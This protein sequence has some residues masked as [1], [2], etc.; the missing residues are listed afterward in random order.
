M[1]QDYLSGQLLGQEENERVT[2]RIRTPLPTSFH[3]LVGREGRGGGVKPLFKH[4]KKLGCITASPSLLAKPLIIPLS[5]FSANF[6]PLHQYSPENVEAA[7]SPVLLYAFCKLRPSLLSNAFSP[8]LL[9]ES[10]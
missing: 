8:L 7:E 5:L 2:N 6:L 10:V 3:A 9:I 1:L 4:T